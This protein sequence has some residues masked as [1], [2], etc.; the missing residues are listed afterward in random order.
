MK[1][2]VMTITVRRRLWWLYGEDDNDAR[3]VMTVAM[4]TE[5][6]TVLPVA[7]VTVMVTVVPVAVVTVMVT[8]CPVAVVTVMVTVLLLLW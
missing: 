3:M 8:L 1:M 7:V 5:M 2:M 6:V 4:V